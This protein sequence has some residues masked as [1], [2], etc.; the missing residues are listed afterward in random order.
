MIEVGTLRR[1]VPTKPP[2]PCWPLFLPRAG[3]PQTAHIPVV[4]I[5]RL[6]VEEERMDAP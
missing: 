4:A 3:P 2:I 1:A 6:A 5:P